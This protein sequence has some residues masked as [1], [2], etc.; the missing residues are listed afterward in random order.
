MSQGEDAKSD[1]SVSL[2]DEDTKTIKLKD[3]KEVLFIEFM[4]YSNEYIKL[5]H[6]MHVN[7][8]RGHLNMARG[9]RSNINRTPGKF[10]NHKNIFNKEMVAIS[11]ITQNKNGILTLQQHNTSS[12]KSQKHTNT[13]RNRTKSEI[14]E[15]KQ[16]NQSSDNDIIDPITW[17]GAM[18]PK[19]MHIAQTDFKNSLNVIVEMANIKQT[20]DKLSKKLDQLNK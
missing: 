1:S 18:V 4:R 20:L 15:K 7:L 10:R 13:L 6:Q 11:T 12:D 9:T 2:S 3:K 8:A 14:E 5:R 16:L 17:F 19:P